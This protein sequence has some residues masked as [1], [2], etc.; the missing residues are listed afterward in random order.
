MKEEIKSPYAREGFIQTHRESCSQSD[1]FCRNEQ[2]TAESGGQ[3]LKIKFE[4]KMEYFFIRSLYEKA[5]SMKSLPKREFVYN[6][7]ID[8]LIDNNQ[9]T[10]AIE[11]YTKLDTLDAKF[12]YFRWVER[13]RLYFKIRE[14][15]EEFDY[16]NVFSQEFEFVFKYDLSYLYLASEI[17]EILKKKVEFWKEVGKET[18]LMIKLQ[19]LGS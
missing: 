17:K 16:F 6:K 9:I 5:L 18:P 12:F 2:L 1:C 7:F 19:Q 10:E 3:S 15:L 14:K 8:F 11:M 4:T 13:C